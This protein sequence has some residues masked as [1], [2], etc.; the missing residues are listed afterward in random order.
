[1]QSNGK[2]TVRV[3]DISRRK[4]KAKLQGQRVSKKHMKGSFDAV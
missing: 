1:M 4:Q 2:N 3:V